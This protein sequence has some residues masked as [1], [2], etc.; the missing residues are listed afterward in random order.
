MATSP[1]L[2]ASNEGLLENESLNF[3]LSLMVIIRGRPRRILRRTVLDEMKSVALG[4]GSAARLVQDR[5]IWR[6][7]VEAL[8]ATGHNEDEYE[9][10]C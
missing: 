10:V 5:A 4:L 7:L 2:P 8:C 9:R 6:D 3:C 1:G